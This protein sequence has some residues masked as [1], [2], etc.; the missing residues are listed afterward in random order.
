M[1]FLREVILR[2]LVEPMVNAVTSVRHVFARGGSA[3]AALAVK[4]L[5]CICGVAI[6]LGPD[7]AAQYLS[8]LIVKLF[9][10]FEKVAVS[11]TLTVSAT[12]VSRPDYMCHQRRLSSTLRQAE[13]DNEAASKFSLSKS[14]VNGISLYFII[15][16]I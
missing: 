7:A 12:P 14:T 3:R 5:D 2:Q 6:R 1:L 8:E 13:A 11:D 4:L 9:K 16:Q 10:P 15:S